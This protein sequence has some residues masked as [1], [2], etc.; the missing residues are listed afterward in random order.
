MHACAKI[1]AAGP[2]SILEYFAGEK[3]GLRMSR[4]ID[5]F[6][7]LTRQGSLPVYIHTCMYRFCINPRKVRIMF[8]TRKTF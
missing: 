2:Q 7:D 1:K 6:L 4:K 8:D 3:P 5:P